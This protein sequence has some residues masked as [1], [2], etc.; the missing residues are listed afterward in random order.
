[1]LDPVF[2]RHYTGPG[3]PERAERLIRI[4][5]ALEEQGL[6]ERCVR[7]EPCKASPE[8]LSPV[9][10]PEYLER[11]ERACLN[12]QPFIDTP[13]S[14]ICPDSFEV[15]LLAAGGVLKAVDLV[16]ERE[17]DAAF[18]AVRPP[19]HHAEAD[20]SMGFCLLNN[21]AL[22]AARLKNHH[23]IGH[24]AVLDWDVHHG[25]GTQ[26]IF[27]EDGDVLYVSLHQSPETLY[28]GTGRAEE[29]GRGSG[30]GATVNIPLAPGTAD[31]EYL[32][33][34]ERIAL[35][36]LTKFAPEFILVSAGFDSH[37]ADPLASLCLSEKVY[38]IL[39]VKTRELAEQ[40]SHGRLVSVL[41]G[42]YD[43]PA[44]GC[45]VAVHLR[46]LLEADPGELQEP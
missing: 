19:G 17:L 25:N 41:E 15:A 2:E 34:L 14:A 33:A 22:A 46:A 35:P 9:H 29:R 45:S 37:A 6:A 20:V 3:H 32:E 44:L 28:P 12:G 10:V 42:G 11:L 31:E 21:V 43:L 13:D 26:H 18:C 38:A 1:M 40:F 4:M 5:Q 39:T 24:L 8:V 30:Q 7:I 23:G 36:A 27:E 16:V